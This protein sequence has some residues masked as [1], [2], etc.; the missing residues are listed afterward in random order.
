[1]HGGKVYCARTSP[2]QC[3]E[4]CEKKIVDI[5]EI[6]ADRETDMKSLKSTVPWE[7]LEARIP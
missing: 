3:L 5:P 6:Y 7:R 2:E 4:G 1:M